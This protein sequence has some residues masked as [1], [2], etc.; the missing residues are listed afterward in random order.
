MLTHDIFGDNRFDSPTEERHAC[1]GIVVR[2]GIILLS[3]ETATDQYF[4][5]GGGLEENETLNECCIR[6][7]SEE[8]G[9]AVNPTEHFLTVNEYYE[10]W[11][12]IS[13]YFRC[14]ITGETERK[15]TKRELDVGL[16]PVWLPLF[17]AIDIFSKHAD[18]RE[19]NEMKRGAYLREY[20]ALS[21]YVEAFN[22]S[23]NP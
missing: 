23:K 3:Y 7:L 8:T 5:P 12:F 4:I 13:H 20:T 6:E 16:V 2:D 14:E 21:F 17:D 10:E 15:L 9:Y 1:R 18:Y 11:H 19:E 22:I